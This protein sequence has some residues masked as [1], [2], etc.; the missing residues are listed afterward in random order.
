M[1]YAMWT[2]LTVAMAA[3][4]W[5]SLRLLVIYLTRD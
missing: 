5:W 3:L 1:R 4:L 2:L